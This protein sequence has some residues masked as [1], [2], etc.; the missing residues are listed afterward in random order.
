MTVNKWQLNNYA[1]PWSVCELVLLLR[2]FALGVEVSPVCY[3]ES[4][5]YQP[6]VA[7]G[8]ASAQLSS[9]FH[10]VFVNVHGVKK[11]RGLR[12][13]QLVSRRYE[14]NPNSYTWRSDTLLAIVESLENYKSKSLFYPPLTCNSRQLK[15]SNHQS[16]TPPHHERHPRQRTS[17]L[18]HNPRHRSTAR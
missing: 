18:G 17:A 15:L 16:K 8:T 14:A 5:P 3:Y 13:I 12:R 1:C 9:A 6:F 11:A 2:T 7:S 10:L 4:L